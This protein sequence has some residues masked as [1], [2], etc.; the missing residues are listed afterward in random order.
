MDGDN[1]GNTLP[2]VSSCGKRKNE[3]LTF[4]LYFASFTLDDH[5]LLSLRLRTHTRRACWSPFFS[6]DVLRPGQIAHFF[7]LSFCSH[8]IFG[9]GHQLLTTGAPK[10]EQLDKKNM[11]RP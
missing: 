7:F 1:T 10:I 3:L 6:A 4:L 2:S 5:W 8:N 9:Q 11:D